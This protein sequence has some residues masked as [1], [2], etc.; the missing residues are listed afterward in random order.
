MSYMSIGG[1]ISE[2]I[3]RIA[4]YPEE[5]ICKNFP[6]LVS[7]SVV[8][9]IDFVA[10]SNSKIQDV[11]TS[12]ISYISTT[13]E[14][15]EHYLDCAKY[16]ATPIVIFQIPQEYSIWNVK[17]T[18]SE[19]LKSGDAEAIIDYLEQNRFSFLPDTIFNAKQEGYQITLFEAFGL[20]DICHDATSKILAEEFIKGINAGKDYWSEKNNKKAA[21]VANKREFISELANITMHIIAA[22]II[23]DKENEST[24]APS[25]ILEILDRMSSKYENYFD[26]KVL[27][28]YSEKMVEAIF[29]ALNKTINYRSID[30]ELLGYFYESFLLNN[31]S[32]AAER[33]RKEMG[34]YYTP[35]YLAEIML[36]SL[37]FEMIKVDDRK[38]FDGTCGSGTL[39][40]SSIKRLEKLLPKSTS[41]DEKRMYL[42]GHI[43]GN[44]MDEIAT[45]VARLSMLLFSLPQSIDWQIESKD[46]FDL[47]ISGKYTFIVANPPF[48]EERKVTRKQKAAVFFLRYMESLIPLGYIC[49]V[50][51]EVFL[52][53]DSC[54]DAREY[55]LSNFDIL[56]IWNLPGSIF[57]N[58]AATIIIIARKTRNQGKIVQIRTLTRN[59]VSIEGFKRYQ[60]WDLEYSYSETSRWNNDS[61]KRI[62][63]SPLVH[64]LDRLE[65]KKNRLG[66]ICKIIIGADLCKDSFE[67]IGNNRSDK[68]IKNAEHFKKYY[69][70]ELNLVDID[71]EALKIYEKT[72]GQK[73]ITYPGLRTRYQNERVFRG[74]KILV[75]RNSTPGQL[76]CVSAAIDDN[77]YIP[78]ISFIVVSPKPNCRYPIEVICAWINSELFQLYA[79]SRYVRRSISID[80]FKKIP[81]PFLDDNQIN[82]IVKKVERII[83]GDDS[84][85]REIDLAFEDYIGL[86][87]EEKKLLRDYKAAYSGEVINKSELIESKEYQYISGTVENIDVVSGK[88]QLSL[89]GSEELIEISITGDMP[90]WFL[91][92]GVMFEARLC[93]G[94]LSEIKPDYSASLSDDEVYEAFL[95][96]LKT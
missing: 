55:L 25:N 49:V 33:F 1:N 15:V 37:P 42:A 31:D 84:A 52:E 46:F 21:R 90:G 50:L 5:N 58:N 70:D 93:Q 9:K 35:K 65:S 19:C 26:K 16:A 54:K 53:N 59:N 39:L 2:R 82:S 75:K 4:G 29:G 13:N 63:Y 79:R 23:Y 64:I 91:R 7:G 27:Y 86:T 34:I 89:F 61:S 24:N 43:F 71:Y 85:I 68:Y 66:D 22:I 32:D 67:V 41:V 38:V 57:N 69:L 20:I 80:T 73:Q 88:V 83:N 10:C 8:E 96:R 56:E 48:S 6:V 3:F 60:T 76:N 51:P 18:S 45:D 77:G 92:N 40:I 87:D 11:S 94:K 72:D 47:D 36:S 81:F 12:C 14:Q 44:D 28:K 62:L 17:K 30:H 74:R 95:R 78:G